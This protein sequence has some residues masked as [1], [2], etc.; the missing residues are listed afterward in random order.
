MIPGLLLTIGLLWLLL[1]AWDRW[2]THRE[3]ERHATSAINLIR[4]RGPEDDPA[5]M[6]RIADCAADLAS[7]READ[8]HEPPATFRCLVCGRWVADIPA[9]SRYF[10]G[11]R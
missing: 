9:H 1:A 10:H 2:D 7:D 8:R 11:G 6:R 5:A 3:W 4:P